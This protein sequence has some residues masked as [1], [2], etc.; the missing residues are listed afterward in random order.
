[1]PDQRRM[2][3]TDTIIDLTLASGTAPVSVDLTSTF[4]TNETRLSQLTLI[5][6]IV[7]IDAA[8]SVHDAGE[9]SQNM[10][11]GIA[12]VARPSLAPVGAIPAP[13]QVSE[14]PI[15]PWVWRYR[16][17][18]F[19]FAAD[20]PAVFVRRVDL[21]LRSQRKVENGEVLFIANNDPEEGV[22]STVLVSGLIRCLYKV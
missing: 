1:M 18:I 15:R 3:W 4:L 6:T 9:G 7:G 12:V 16:S 8:Y 11:C 13:N 22:A 14:Y 19:G 5:R 20:Q 2:L 17:R 21:D 10:T